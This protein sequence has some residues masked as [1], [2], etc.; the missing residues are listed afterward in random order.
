MPISAA[1]IGVDSLQRIIIP[2]SFAATFQSRKLVPT[3]PQQGYLH[4]IAEI[5]VGKGG[6]IFQLKTG[7]L[8]I[9]EE[10]RADVGV[11]IATIGNDVGDGPSHSNALGGASVEKRGQATIVAIHAA[12][13]E[14]GGRVLLH[15]SCTGS[16]DA[17]L[18]GMV[19]TAIHD[20]ELTI[21]S[22]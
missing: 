19:L 12:R 20:D 14:A 22:Y 5:K 17:Q 8:A 3:P 7:V 1:Q 6:W 11:Q 15:V 18:F 4:F 2:S 21:F 16:S 10:G 9:D 13:F